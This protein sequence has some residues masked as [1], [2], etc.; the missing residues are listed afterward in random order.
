[1]VSVP[2]IDTP[3]GRQASQPSH[4]R[5]SGLKKATVAAASAA[6]IFAS[7]CGIGGGGGGNEKKDGLAA[8]DYTVVREDDVT[9]SIIVN[10]N[11]GP[12]RS[13]SITTPLQSKVEKLAVAAGDRV[14]VDQFLVEMDSSAAERQLAQQQQQQANAQAE[15]MDG[16]EAAQA[17]LNTVQDQINRGVHPAIGQAQAAVNQAQAAYDAAVAGQGAVA[18]D[19]SASQVKRIINDIS[20]GD[21]LSGGHPAPAPSPAPSPEQREQQMIQQRVAE[22][23]MAQAQQQAQGQQQATDQAAVGQAYAALQQAYAQL[24]VAYAQ[25]AQER[26]QLQRQVDSAWRQAETAGNA[27]GDGSLEYQVQSATVYAPMAGLVTSVDVQEGDIPQGKLLTIAD[28]SR[29]LIR[30]QVRE[31]DVLDIAPGNR[32]KFTSTAT[33]NKEFEGRVSWVSPVANSGEGKTGEGNPQGG[34]AAV[35]FPVDI[36]V[37]GDKEGLLLGGSARAEIITEEDSDSLS[38]PLDAVFEDGGQKKVLVLSTEDGERRGAVEERKVTTGAANEVDVAVT[39]GEL[40][41][42]DIVINWPDQYRDRLGENVSISDT[43]FNPD[44]VA[45]AREENKG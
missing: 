15:A 23:Q 27:S 36:E 8:G 44:D 35:T 28:D 34:Q 42:G 41:K 10:G 19:A 32:V 39:G 43:K 18:M 14:S 13:M 2:G 7:A 1:M 26:D 12:A 11:I 37:T 16:V 3:Y 25:A 21:I 17:Q 24:D 33:G 5:R 30:S 38:V 31:G 40:T 45:A 9:N 22:Q 4:K 6:I 29:L 20:S